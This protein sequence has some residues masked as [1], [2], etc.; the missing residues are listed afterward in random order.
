MLMLWR[1]DEGFPYYKGEGH[2]GNIN[3]VRVEYKSIDSSESKQEVH[4]NRWI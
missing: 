2:A 1:Y 3:R 4:N